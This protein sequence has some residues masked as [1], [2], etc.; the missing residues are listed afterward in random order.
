MA[1]PWHI[2]ASHRHA[3]TVEE[4]LPSA[5]VFV[6]ATKGGGDTV[7]AFFRAVDQQERLS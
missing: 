5:A 6:P 2:R 1:G 7:S 4:L 3:V